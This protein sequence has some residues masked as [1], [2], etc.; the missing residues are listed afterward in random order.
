M[1]STA[2]YAQEDPFQML[3]SSIE[4]IPALYGTYYYAIDA[5]MYAIILIG[6]AQF[7]LSKHFDGRGGKAVIIGVGVS[8]ALG[9]SFFE[10]NNK[11]Q[12]IGGLGPIAV[13]IVLIIFLLFFYRLF[14][15][16][17]A[18]GRIMGML[19]FSLAVFYI[20]AQFPVIGTW[21]RSKGGMIAFAWNTLILSALISLPVAIIL[22]IVKLVGSTGLG[23]LLTDT[24]FTP[25]PATPP[26]Q[27]PPR[28]PGPQQPPNPTIPTPQ[29]THALSADGGVILTWNNPGGVQGYEIFRADAAGANRASIRV[30]NNPTETVFFDVI[31]PGTYTYFIR[32]ISGGVPSPD[33]NPIQGMSVTGRANV[34]VRPANNGAAFWVSLTR[35]A[36][37]IN[38]FTN[39][40]VGNPF[41][42]Y[43]ISAGWT[44]IH[45]ITLNIGTPPAWNFTQGVLAA[46]QYVALSTIDN[47]SPRIVQVGSI[48]AFNTQDV[49]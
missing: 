28:T 49:A 4:K 37:G 35:P 15:H 40:N 33:S 31:A 29:F 11:F 46:S 5:I 17:G 25:T 7:A 21:A 13:I 9:A 23:K 36:A 42:I 38:F 22:G 12:L 10:Y 43:V 45:P 8:L 47:S 34:F 41:T 2:V 39:A 48:C 16:L 18:N 6:A 3:F 26:G 1:L 20:T 27:P 19:M 14:T 44:G 32:G 24:S 30:M